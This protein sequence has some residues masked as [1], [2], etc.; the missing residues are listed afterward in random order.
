[1]E[2]IISAIISSKNAEIST[3]EILMC[4][5]R[6]LQS[7]NAQLKK[8]NTE[9]QQENTQLKQKN[10]ILIS[11]NNERRNDIIDL[12]KSNNVLESKI[13]QG[14]DQL[15]DEHTKLQKK[16]DEVNMKNSLFHRD[17]LERDR[18]NDELI[19]K[20]NELIASK[21]EL[22]IQLK[23]SEHTLEQIRTLTG[24]CTQKKTTVEEK[25]VEAPKKPV[26]EEQ[27]PIKIDLF[28]DAWE[29]PKKQVKKHID[30]SN[31]VKPKLSKNAMKTREIV[32]KPIQVQNE[33]L[34]NIMDDLDFLN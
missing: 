12:Q 27:K 16:Y 3:L 8:E 28:N 13:S 22:K 17:M 29:L 30:T 18:E 2:T 31:L 1:M 19:R 23:L 5:I 4:Q 11:K 7:E 26:V 33:T 9:L 14:Y 25:I 24:A 20:C 10:V 15:Y 34:E 6:Q 32:S 21:K